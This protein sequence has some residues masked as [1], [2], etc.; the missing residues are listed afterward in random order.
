MTLQET[1]KEL[2]LIRYD[3]RSRD[4]YKEYYNTK[5][6]A[7]A[8]IRLTECVMDIA[9]EVRRL[10]AVV[11]TLVQAANLQ[12]AINQASAPKPEPKG[13]EVVL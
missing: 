4:Q 12:S 11:S 9:A 3:V 8:N 13:L 5:V 7:E 1:I 2:E 10:G 6:V